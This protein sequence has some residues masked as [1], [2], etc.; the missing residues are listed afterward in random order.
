[1]KLRTV[2]LLALGL[3][4]LGACSDDD[5]SAVTGPGG[6][7]ALIRFVNATADTGTVD[8]RFVDR[9][10]NLPTFLGVPFR[11]VSGAGY[12]AV[13]A[14]TRPVR[15]FVN[16]TNPVEAQKMLVDTTI[17]LAADGRYTLVYAGN[18]RGNA[19]RLAV[20]DDEATLPAPT[21]NLAIRVLHAA[22]GTG[23]ATVAVLPA[24]AEASD[25]PMAT[26]D[27]VDYLSLSAY[28][29]VAARPSGTGNLYTFAVT[30]GA[31]SY[32]V[33]PNEPGAPAPAGQ[34]YGPT[35]G[36][37]IPGSVITV[38]L[39]PGAT[40]GAPAATA[41]NTTPSVVILFDKPVSGS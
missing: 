21:G 40:E 18:A 4:A 10:E 2:V 36:M 15:V 23:A 7:Q 13:A 32:S 25:T 34:L 33:T 37:Q 31:A 16:S 8:F 35:P 5:G 29:N 3:T 12:I 39:V 22:A 11:G 41:T 6:P 26:F 28:Q 19:D 30:A 24:G 38:V 27:N 9:L 17:T 14:G 20:I 1:M